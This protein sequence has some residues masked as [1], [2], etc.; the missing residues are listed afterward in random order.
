MNGLLLVMA[1]HAPP[2]SAGPPLC[3]WYPGDPPHRKY[4]CYILTRL[5]EFPDRPP[6]GGLP[7]G[8]PTKVEW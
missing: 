4:L 5:G 2:D 3:P 8:T 1:L 7:V 6:Y